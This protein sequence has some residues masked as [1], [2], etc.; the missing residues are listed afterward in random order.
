MSDETKLLWLCIALI[1]VL[2]ALGACKLPDQ[3]ASFN[4]DDMAFCKNYGSKEI[5]DNVNAC[6]W[7]VDECRGRK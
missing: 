5:C 6:T 4:A 7:V 2:F 3:K 1:F